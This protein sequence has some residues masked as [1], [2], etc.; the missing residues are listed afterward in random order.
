MVKDFSFGKRKRSKTTSHEQK[1][2]KEKGTQQ[3]KTQNGINSQLYEAQQ[4]PGRTQ[5]AEE[6]QYKTMT[7]HVLNYTVL[8]NTIFKASPPES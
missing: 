8:Q 6:G 2:T 4:H 1:E 5:G 7:T 3:V